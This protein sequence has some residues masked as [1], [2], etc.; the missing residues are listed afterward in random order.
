[1]IVL[2]CSGY[3]YGMSYKLQEAN[4]CGSVICMQCA[5]SQFLYDTV[6]C[7]GYVCVMLEEEVLC[8]FY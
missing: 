8:V 7:M 1:M 2:N 4:V 3:C 5:W 6:V